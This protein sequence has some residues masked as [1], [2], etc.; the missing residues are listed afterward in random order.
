MQRAPAPSVLVVGDSPEAVGLADALAADGVRTAVR[1]PARFGGRLSALA[2]WD[3]CVVVD[4][5]ASAFGV[6]RLATLEAMVSERGQGLILTGGRQ[7]FLQGG[8]Q[9]TALSRLSPLLLAAPPHGDREA[10]AL[11]LLVDRSA[12][13]AG[14]DLSTRLTSST[15]RARPPCWPPRSSGR[16]TRSG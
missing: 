9:G 5:P 1:G 13:L 6:D 2:E 15:W 16:A 10:V 7:S 12:S 8:W 4:L 11:L 14:G 3:A